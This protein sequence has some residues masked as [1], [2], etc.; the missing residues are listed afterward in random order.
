MGPH[1]FINKK[2][3]IKH[4]NIYTIIVFVL[5]ICKSV[6]V[7]VHCKTHII[8]HTYMITNLFVFKLLSF[9]CLSSCI[10]NV[11]LRSKIACMQNKRMLFNF[12]TRYSSFFSFGREHF[13]RSFLVDVRILEREK[14][15]FF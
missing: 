6:S 15:T 9:F 8:I 1:I 13:A 3:L 2:S 4:N 11:L 14:V 5:H 10:F 7:C 12:L